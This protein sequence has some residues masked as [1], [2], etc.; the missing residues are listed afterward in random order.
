[1]ASV[2]SS[3]LET[4]DLNNDM[5]QRSNSTESTVETLHRETK[6]EAGSSSSTTSTSLSSIEPVNE[7]HSRSMTYQEHALPTFEASSADSVS[8]RL[9][10]LDLL[11]S[12]LLVAVPMAFYY[13]MRA[14]HWE[15]SSKWCLEAKSKDKWT[16]FVCHWVYALMPGF[17][18]VVVM[19]A[20][21]YSGII[22]A[23]KVHLRHHQ[24]THDVETAIPYPDFQAEDE[25]LSVE[26][27]NWDEGDVVYSRGRMDVRKL[28]QSFVE[29]GVGK[30]ENGQ[31][32]VTVFAGGPE[33]YVD[34]I[35]RHV[36]KSSWTVEFHRETWAP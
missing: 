21:G 6:Q 15:G 30:K 12:A 9:A 10:T 20:L 18:H 32:L 23:R 26:D 34:M 36:K 33:G 7:K 5:A 27:G 29:S 2:V 28:V 35:E 25:K 16:I 11:T 13:G 31:G 19:L 3:T 17:V 8:R 22:I 24:G 14:V 1:M 4:K